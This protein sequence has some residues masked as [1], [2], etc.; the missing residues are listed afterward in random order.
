M[1]DLTRWDKAAFTTLCRDLLKG[2][3]MAAAREFPAQNVEQ[4]FRLTLVRESTDK[5]FRTDEKWLCIFAC[6]RGALAAAQTQPMAHAAIA[7]DVGNLLLVVFGEVAPETETQLR[8]ALATEGIRVALLDGALAEAL[9]KDY[10]RAAA[11]RSQPAPGGFSFARLRQYAQEQVS[12]APWRKH[13]QTTSIQPMRLLPLNRADAALSEADLFRVLQGASFLLLGDPGAGKTTSLLAL[14]DALAKA[15]GQTP[16]FLPLGRYRGDFWAVLCEALAPGAPP[17]AK[18]VAQALVASGALVLMLDGINEVQNPDLQEQLVSDLNHLTDPAEPFA[19]GR[20]I[21]SGRVHDY[22]QSRNQLAHLG[23]GR[24]EVQPLTADLVFQFLANALGEAP[25]R[26]LYHALGQTVRDICANPLLLNML[27]TVYQETGGAPAGRSALYRRFVELMLRWGDD[28]GL[29]TGERET[30][31]ALFAEELTEARYQTMAMEALTAL[32]TAMPTT[33]IQWSEASK[34][35]VLTL[36][37]SRHP[38]QAAALLLEDLTRRGILRRDVFNRISF[39]HHTFQE[40]FQARQ[41]TSRSVDELIPK[42]GVSASQREAVIF[43]AGMM[44]N[45]APLIERAIDVDLSLAF[46]MVRDSAQSIPPALIRL[47]AD[48]LWTDAIKGGGFTGSK[49]RSAIMFSQLANLE[50]KTVAVVAAEIDD[51]LDQVTQTGRLM[52]FYAELGDAKAQQQALA[53]VVINE[54]VP[55]GLLFQAAVAASGSRNFERAIELYTQYLKKY[56]DASGAYNNRAIAHKA[57]GHKDTAL[58]D[59]KQAIKLEGS[60]HHYANLATLLNDLGRREEALE[61]IRLAL[62]REP[63]YATAHSRLAD[64]LESKDLETALIHR[65]HAVSYAPHDDALRRTYLPKLADSQEQLGRHAGAIRTLR[66]LIA[67]DP[68]SPKIKDWKTRIANLRQALDA[69]ERTRSARERLQEQGELPLPTLALEWLRAAGLT[70]KSPSSSWLLAEGGRGLPAKLPVALLP[71]P[72]VTGAGLRS[73]LEAMPR[74]VRP[75]KQII[76]VAAAET[77]SPEARHQLAALQDEYTAALT[78]ALEVRD[79]LLQSDRECRLLLDRALQRA[80]RTDNPFEYTGVVREH[81]EFFGRVADIEQLTGLLG[82]GQQVGL[83]G[84]HKIGKSSLLEQLRRKLHISNPDITVVQIELDASLKETGD[85]YRRVLEK[86]PALIELAPTQAVNATTFRQVLTAFHRQRAKD[87]P[88]HRL[89]L[90][91]DEYAYLIPDRRGA[92]GLRNFIEVLGLLKALYQEGWLLVLPCGRSAA[93]NRQAG[94]DGAE[95]PF[96]GLL[97]A[98]F[99]GPLPRE[100]NDALMTT[101]GVR[102][103]LTFTKEALAT[104]YEETGGH[105]LFS[106]ALGSQILRAGAG[107]VTPQAVAQAV[108]RF[109]QDHDQ[110]AIPRVIYE[111][112]LDKDEQEIARRLALDGPQPP[113]SLFPTEA[114]VDRRRQ[115][116][117]A[118]KNLIDT[119]VL[120]QLADGRVAHRYGLMRRVIEQEMRELGFE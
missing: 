80:G 88:S 16:V 37:E 79:A 31:R 13:F 10:S 109:L 38:E 90:M 74:E 68:T 102:S 61:Q 20:W 28:R 45:P 5:M 33:M 43:V 32:A 55:E 93:L 86:L 115:I 82:R 118:L 34:Q 54:E 40:Y 78:T 70:V 99:L 4:A 58:K 84:I 8:E 56:P 106:R 21:V 6:P 44:S 11:F 95:N 116:R 77:L 76:V 25:G 69:E 89:L 27:L 105:P 42:S 64:W 66:H 111:E 85:F 65:E 51:Y 108:A 75:A 120:I 2:L 119:T 107:K 30:L 18:S 71:D 60:A 103:K 23:A 47:L 59:Y 113:A 101:L 100:E 67:L 114:D 29:Q 98:N 3:G 52:T 72:V 83:Y 50:G 110:S 112:R 49:R 62:K 15:G 94:W 63:T 17:V 36:S 19:H 73:L 22:Q 14:A 81:T 24:W 12:A 92:G 97:H 104:I 7:A 39:F 96:V 87:R 46:E 26:T 117:D 1:T 91:L 57:L 9:A 35:C 48:G 41:L 53:Q